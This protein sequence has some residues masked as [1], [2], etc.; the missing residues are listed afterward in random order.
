MADVL[1]CP[2]CGREVVPIATVDGHTAIV[3]DLTGTEM[4]VARVRCDACG[5]WA[6]FRSEKAERR[7]ERLSC[8]RN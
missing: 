6:W 2:N 8:H 5:G 4:L 1:R 3:D 7:E